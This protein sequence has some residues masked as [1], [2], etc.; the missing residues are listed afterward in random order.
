[1][2]TILIVDDDPGTRLFLEE[3]LHREGYRVILAA[4]GQEALARLDEGDCDLV[5]MDIR[6]PVLDGYQTTRQFR[7]RQQAWFVPVIFLTSVQTD[8]EL[9][10]CLECGGDDFLTKPPNPVI[11]RARIK[12]WLQRA[13]LANRLAKNRQ[14]MEDVILKMR[15][16]DQFDAR[17]LRV[18]M[19]PLEKTNGDMVL[20]ACRSDGVQYL[21]VGDFTGHGLAAA[22]CGPLVTDTFYRQ[23]RRDL[24]LQHIINQINETI[25]R[26]L[27][28][29]MFLAAAFLELDREKGEMFVWNAALPAVTVVRDGR[30][31]EQIPSGL[32]PLGI[33]PQL[34]T[35]KPCAHRVL[36]RDDRIYLFTD[37][38]VETQSVAGEFFGEERMVRFLETLSPAETELD[39]LL[40]ELAQF[41]AGKEQTDDITVVEVKW[42]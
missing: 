38:S 6:M 18:L 19:T 31:A 34:P 37:G 25:F 26:R 17:G 3:L 2:T 35:S 28:V 14:D 21:M 20:S 39:A 7:A 29:N 33:S 8:Q 23:T 42:A 12:A 4:D 22:I 1:M 11:L 40:T 41:R 16:D 13:D 30:L 32:P 9:A 5:L 10:R 24:P 15:Q 36:A 27:P